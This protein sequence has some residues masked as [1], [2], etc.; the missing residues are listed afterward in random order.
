MLKETPL[1]D[2]YWYAS[3]YKDVQILDMDPEAHYYKYGIPMG[4]DPNPFFDAKAYADSHGLKLGDNPLEHFMKTYGGAAPADFPVFSMTELET[5][6]WGG[7]SGLTV[8][9]LKSSL[10]SD[11]Y[12][13]KAKGEAAFLLG[14]WYALNNDWL[15]SVK[16]LKMIRNFD[17]KLFRSQRCKLLLVEAL[18]NVGELDKAGEVIDY[19]LTQDLNGH[20]ICAR[21]N[22]LMAQAPKGDSEA[23]LE[24]LN[25]LYRKNGLTEMRLKDAKKGLIF[26]NWEYDIPAPKLVYGP[27]VSVL[28]PVYG[29]EEFI[30]VAIRSLLAQ[31]WNNLE[32]IAIEDRS[33]DNSWGRLQALAEEDDRLKIYRND[34]NMGAYPT[35]NRALSLATGDFITVHDSD[36]WSHPQ[37]IEMQMKVMLGNP[38]LKGTC[39]RMARV[40]P[41]LRFIL[42]P[43]RKNLEYVH[44]S[45][46][47]LLM[48]R[49]D[50]EALKQ[51]DQISAN[52]DDEFIQRARML[53]GDE[54][55]LDIMTNVPLSL[56]LVH[57]NSLTQQKGTNLNSLTFG[58]RC[59]Y[60]RQA[61]YWREHKQTEQPQALFL[62]R[63]SL[64]QP[65]PIPAGLAPKN[66]DRNRD[67]DIVL[68]SDL[69]LLGGTRRCNEGYI[70]AAT[71]LGLRVGLF[72]WPRFDLRQ[73]EINDVYVELTYQD[74]V[75]IL[76]PEDKINAKLILVHH[77]PILKY[78]IDAVPQINAKK[79]AIIVNQ[80]PMQ[81]W[82]HPP[83]YY[84]ADDVKNLC[85]EMFGLE[86]EWIAISRRVQEILRIS[87]G[88]EAVLDSLWYP[89][90]SGNLPDSLPALP[91]GFGSDR[92]IVIGRQSRDHWTKWPAISQ[93]LLA[94]YC[95]NEHGISTHILGG[96][97]TPKK[98]LKTLPDNWKVLEFDAVSVAE[99]IRGLDFFLHFVHE[100]YI[101]EFGRNVM[102]AMS[103]GRVAILPQSF[104]DIFGDAAVYC[105]PSEVAGVVRELWAQPDRY[106][107]IAQRGLDFVKQNCSQAVVQIR[108][109]DMMQNA[110]KVE[111]F[112]LDN[113]AHP[114][115]S[116]KDCP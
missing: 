60:A 103:A 105:R 24:S 13:E 23:R 116:D 106:C 74:N 51:W 64:K 53:W 67:Y 35:R 18:I 85:L 54:A 49:A 41:D 80:S 110:V 94:A 29:A 11:R 28:V 66:W 39:S 113:E 97:H 20:F 86:P 47:S 37:M 52:A 75:D 55:I 34:V 98:V 70:Q 71:S 82:S 33:S 21:N 99:F 63:T 69:G 114:N 59:E 38:E 43:Q 96:A 9:L 93:S 102:E 101:E 7:F 84:N 68:V 19:V 78:R 62:E 3:K 112:G 81:C 32:I 111:D 90:H 72:H 73:S 10:N 104:R 83:H 107:E 2:P 61:K 88:F 45:Y 56:F 6:L 58:I 8:D 17:I 12:D 30:D 76:V 87:C 40:Y 79:L 5:K 65:F 57:E 91:K 1:F 77:P 44:R 42:R 36:D 14:R 50:I 48:R 109:N 27:K 25:A 89:P 108:L 15:N 92:P 16:H 26:G 4:R 22:L 115:Q 95:A 31:T 46:P 100:D